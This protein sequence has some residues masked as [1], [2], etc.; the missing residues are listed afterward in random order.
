MQNGSNVRPTQQNVHCTHIFRQ[1]MAF[2][3]CFLLKK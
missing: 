3:R 2:L 1:K